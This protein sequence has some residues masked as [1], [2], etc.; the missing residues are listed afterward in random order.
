MSLAVVVEILESLGVDINFAF[1]AKY[2]VPLLEAG[3]AFFVWTSPT[4][5]AHD[6]SAC[7]CTRFSAF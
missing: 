6:L 5:P 4:R 3:T 1:Q 2:W 7:A